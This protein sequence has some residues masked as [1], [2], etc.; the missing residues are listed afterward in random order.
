MQETISLDDF[1]CEFWVKEDLPPV[2]LMTGNI[3]GLF[4]IIQ[5]NAFIGKAGTLAAQRCGVEIKSEKDFSEFKQRED[6][7]ALVQAIGDDPTLR[8]EVENVVREAT[9]AA[10]EF[11]TNERFCR[12][13]QDAVHLFCEHAGQLEVEQL[14][15]KRGF[16][17]RGVR[18]RRRTTLT[19][20]DR[21]LSAAEGTSRG[22]ETGT[23]NKA[24]R[25]NKT[26]F[27]KL[28]KELGSGDENWNSSTV[29]VRMGYTGKDVS[30]QLRRD[31]QR[32]WEKS[33]SEVVNDILG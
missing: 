13:L 11:V 2:F 25:F 9:L 12:F 7:G 22:R 10:R 30:R 5:Q 8:V 16:R 21:M 26:K 29:A 14:R 20:A 33:Y 23:P 27:E 28:V 15:I 32:Y 19:N 24:V 18:E 1:D 31:V 3:V 6:F 17:K 4:A